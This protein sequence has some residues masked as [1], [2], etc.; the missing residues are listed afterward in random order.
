MLQHNISFLDAAARQARRGG[1]ACL[2][3]RTHR[4]HDTGCMALRGG[5]DGREP[6]HQQGLR[7]LLG[8]LTGLRLAVLTRALICAVA[9]CA[10]LRLGGPAAVGGRRGGGGAAA[11]GAGAERR[12]L[13]ALRH[14]WA[15]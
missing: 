3:C 15:T 9:A 2:R 10:G 8:R 11:A 4:C 14:V 5:V 12:G 13:G 6:L 7:L 1:Q